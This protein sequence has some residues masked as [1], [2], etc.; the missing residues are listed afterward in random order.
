MYV[1]QRPWRPGRR[2]VGSRLG[3]R[4]SIEPA[5]S[6]P[7]SQQQRCL[8]LGPC[9]YARGTVHGSPR[10]RPAAALR[11]PAPPIG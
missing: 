7:A 8:Q 3:S 10:A 2:A 4:R 9:W 6:Q 1:A 11:L 5:S